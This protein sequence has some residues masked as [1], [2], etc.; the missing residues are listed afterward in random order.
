MSRV[1]FPFDPLPDG[2]VTP[3]AGKGDLQELLQRDVR[4]VRW[5]IEEAGWTTAGIRPGSVGSGISAGR[6]P[7]ILAG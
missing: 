1:H 6:I 3:H 2:E 4:I 5:F 7:E